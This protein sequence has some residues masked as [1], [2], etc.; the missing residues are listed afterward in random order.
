MRVEVVVFGVERERAIDFEERLRI[1]VSL[2]NESDSRPR[3]KSYRDTRSF[4]TFFG[5]PNR[6][7]GC[8][9]PD[10]GTVTDEVVDG[11]F[12][13]RNTARM[14][15]RRFLISCNEIVRVPRGQRR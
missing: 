3:I 15:G 12:A 4:E 9:R 10:E 7:L 14:A 13:A 1:L 5:A 11:P 8:F 2:F 6:R